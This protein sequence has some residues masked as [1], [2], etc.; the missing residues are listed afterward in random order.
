MP[1]SA[2]LCFLI[3]QQ[4]CA[5]D[6][7]HQVELHG[8]AAGRRQHGQN[9]LHRL[10][11]R[12]AGAGA[13]ISYHQR[14]RVQHER[15]FD[16]LRCSSR[17]ARALRRDF[18]HPDAP[19]ARRTGDQE[20]YFPA[21]SPLHWSV[22]SD[23]I[24][25]WASCMGFPAP[26]MVKDAFEGFADLSGGCCMAYGAICHAAAAWLAFTPPYI[27][28]SAVPAVLRRRSPSLSCLHAIFLQRNLLDRK[29]S[30]A[31]GVHRLCGLGRRDAVCL[32]RA[33][34]AL[35]LYSSKTEQV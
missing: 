12:R 16:I 8:A 21:I 33:I 19:R 27:G 28:V 22:G 2:Q 35:G 18:Q 24:G 3:R 13:H 29:R 34:G 31:E 11:Q 30:A 7:L 26:V 23:H 17:A 6:G 1:S 14:R 5:G 20:A 15:D 32:P 9:R 4:L 10:L 25:P